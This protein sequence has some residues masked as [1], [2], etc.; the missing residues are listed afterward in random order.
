MASANTHFSG[1]LGGNNSE[2]WFTEGSEFS[3]ST[4]NPTECLVLHYTHGS[5]E[6]ICGAF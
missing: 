5:K 6:Q 4:D 3:Q 1:T 2:A